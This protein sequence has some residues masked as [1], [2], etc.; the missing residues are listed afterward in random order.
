M[1]F[2]M[3][4]QQRALETAELLEAILAQLSPRDL[5][6]AQRISRPFYQTIKNSPHLQILLF[7]RQSFA[8][9]PDGWCLNQLLREQFL[10]WFVTPQP[11]NR[12]PGYEHIQL[13]DG[14][15]VEKRREAFLRKEASWRKMLL[16][17]PSAL[18]LEIVK[19]INSRRDYF[20][21]TT[22]FAEEKSAI[23]TATMGTIYDITESFVRHELV[24]SFGLSVIDSDV[25][26]QITL[27]LMYVQQCS[28]SNMYRKWDLRSKGAQMEAHDLPFE[29]LQDKDGKRLRV[30]IPW[31]SDLSA[32]RG[33]VGYG[34]FK[35]W[36]KARSVIR[37][38]PPGTS[39]AS[40]KDDDSEDYE[41]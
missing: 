34:E 24:S 14:L 9:A 13:L 11:L 35:A 38:S 17:Q 25:G 15:D 37:H 20:G 16:V 1:A 21:K 28:R 8:K 4:A 6:L 5:L 32:E 19:H 39:A 18:N 12:N 23:G 29:L 22:I 33:G 36:A 40:S 2:V 27:Y 41:S 31:K 10:P 30:N 7:F 26:P 3:S